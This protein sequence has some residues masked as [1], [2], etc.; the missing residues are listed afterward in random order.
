MQPLLDLAEELKTKDVPEL[1]A[2]L[3]ELKFPIIKNLK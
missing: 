3:N 1:N 2:L